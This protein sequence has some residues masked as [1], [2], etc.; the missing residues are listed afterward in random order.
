MKPMIWHPE[1]KDAKVNQYLAQMNHA[2]YELIILL[3][4]GGFC[5]FT[6]ILLDITIKDVTMMIQTTLKAWGQK[7]HK[8]SSSWGSLLLW[9]CGVGMLVM[10]MMTFAHRSMLIAQ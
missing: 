3:L 8:D 4:L 10:I 9:F 1:E 2:P 7:F 6:L 5:F